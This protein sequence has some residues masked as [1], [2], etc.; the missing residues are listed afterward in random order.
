MNSLPTW[1]PNLGSWLSALF[2]TVLMWLSGTLS[3]YIWRWVEWLMHWS[4]KVGYFVYALALLFPVALIALAHHWLHRYLDQFYPESRSPEV[5][6]TTGSFPGLM[7]WWEGLYGWWVSLLSFT[8]SAVIIG[9][10]LTPFNTASDFIPWL[11]QSWSNW[12]VT[13]VRIIIAAFLYQFEYTV[14]RHL[15]TTGTN[16]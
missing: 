10:I 11:I 16:R 12:S 7:S 5:D 13:I 3:S 4:P 6:P 15:I 8:L 9:I 1:I 2:L 14:R